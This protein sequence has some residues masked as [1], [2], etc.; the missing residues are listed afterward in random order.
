M[1]WM[2]LSL[3]LLSTFLALAQGPDEDYVQIYNLI[4]QADTLSRGGDARG[5]TQKYAEAQ[6]SLS[7]LHSSYPKWNEEVVKFRLEYLADKLQGVP[8]TALGTNAPSTPPRTPGGVASPEIDSQVRSLNQEVQRLSTENASLEAKLREALAVRP[9][10]VDPRELAKT[11][12]QLLLS[13]KERDLLKVSLEQEQ[14]KTAAKKMAEELSRGDAKRLKQLEAERSGWQKKG[15]DLEKKI[16]ALNKELSSATTARTDAEKSRQADATKLTQLQQ[17]RDELERKLKQASAAEARRADDAKQQEAAALKKV[18]QQRDELQKNL[19]AALSDVAKTKATTADAAKVKQLEQQRADLQKSLNTA[20]A[21]LDRQ[22]QQLVRQPASPSRESDKIKQLEQERS[23]LLK[24]LAEISNEQRRAPEVKPD[25]NAAARLADL[26][27]QR[28]DLQTRLNSALSELA[29]SKTP[30]GDSKRIKQLE[31]ERDDLSRKLAAALQEANDKSRTKSAPS[32]SS[33]DKRE[34][35][36]LKAR[37]EVLEA[38]PSPFTAEERAALSKPSVQAMAS[39]AT[40]PARIPGPEA[41]PEVKPA[42]KS[43]PQLPPGAGELVAQAERAFEARRYSEAEKK[44]LELLQQDEKNVYTLSH[45]AAVYLEERRF[46]DADNY[47][48]RALESDPED[49]FSLSLRG[50]VKYDQDKYDEAID[51]L[52]RAVKI[53]PK[54]SATQVFMGLALAQKGQRG[55]AEAALRKALELQPNNPDAH[56]NLALLYASQKPPFLELARWHYEK[57]TGAGIGRNAD[58]EKTLGIK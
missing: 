32:G 26:Q 19:N 43:G 14:A 16:T 18:E 10:S 57:A 48:G 30:T 58:L 52:S 3:L 25:Q 31:Q 54:R 20:Q 40:P 8:R 34:M 23:D 9:A 5:A 49:E 27:K 46:V 1:K 21:E 51:Y 56:Y 2:P 35:A 50:V 55:P 41:K 45:L 6:Q 15:D 42:N 29:K 38:R 11:Q 53:N 47:L 39:P 17:D 33:S 4:Q 37:L 7:K 36:R 13:Q 12:E 24:R 22:A 28:D 44:Y